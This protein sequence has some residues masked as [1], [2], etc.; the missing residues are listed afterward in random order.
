MIDLQALQRGVA[1]GADV[2]GAA[3]DAGDRRPA[4]ARSRGAAALDA[5]LGRHDRLF[6]PTFEGLAD[7][8]LIGEG[9]VHVRGVE[10][11]DPEVQGAVD[12]G[13]GLGLV[14][15]AVEVGHPHAAEALGGDG[16]SLGAECALFHG[17][18]S[19]LASSG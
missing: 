15:P 2:L 8:F 6:A 3:A 17:R 4:A 18:F 11:V 13:D 7:E 9:A 12:G 10:E 5:E 1:S 16:Q 14:A 19:L